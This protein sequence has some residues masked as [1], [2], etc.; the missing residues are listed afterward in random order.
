MEVLFPDDANL[1][2]LIKTLTQFSLLLIQNLK[3][4][5]RGLSPSSC[6]LMLNVYMVL[7]SASLKNTV[8]SI[9]FAEP[10]Y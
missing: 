10:S 4:S 6:L 7:T 8:S 2:F 9:D 1:F 5:Q 3:M